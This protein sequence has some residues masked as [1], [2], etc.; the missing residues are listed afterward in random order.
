MKCSNCYV[1]DHT[2]G[3][4]P[5]SETPPVQGYLVFKQR[6]VL[7]HNTYVKPA[8]INDKQFQAMI[9][10]GCLVTLIRFSPVVRSRAKL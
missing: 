9:D 4:C 5:Q 10:I 6:E 1:G 8:Y 7:P 3:K 2:R